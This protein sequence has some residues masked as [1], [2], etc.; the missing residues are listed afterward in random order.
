MS[1]V[2]LNVS[3]ISK[4][5]RHYN[6]E[7]L[8][9]ASWFGLKSKSIEE[10]WTLRNVNFLIHS[11]EAIGIVGQN[12]AGKSTLLKIITGTL[13]P[14]VGTVSLH[15]RVSAILELGMGFHP[16]LTG[17]ENA[18]HS[19]GM[20]GFTK[21]QIDDVIVHIE[22][23]AEIGDYFDQ[24]VRIYSSGMQMRV[25][26][27]VATA[28]RPQILIVDEALS[29]GDAYFQHKSFNRIREF[30]K[31]GT[32]LLLVSHDKSAIQAICD[33]A[34]LLDKG[35]V[36]KDGNPEEVMDFYNALIAMK[37]NSELSQTTLDSGKVQTISG[38][39]EVVIQ[40][41]VLCDDEDKAVEVVNVGNHVTLKIKTKICQNISELVLGYIIKD[42]LGQTIFGTNTH[43]LKH[44]IKDAK[45]GDEIEYNFA[46]TANLG[47]G[48]YSV[49]VAAHSTESHLSN[50]YEWKD[51][52]LIFTVINSNKNHF[53]GACWIEP[54][55]SINY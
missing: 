2:I 10:N 53:N 20:M 37:E 55:C 19:A 41:V 30:Q 38:T 47:E 34:I 8:R 4:A 51:M 39:G 15:G 16:D 25:A 14:T 17:R 45:M 9:V 42:R 22:S 24:P 28:Y 43:H 26:F 1:P 3:N 31:Q 35:T 27:A 12:G 11:G 48:S 7:W 5:Y 40:S 23:F 52:A 54:I 44:V 49:T 33:R 6:S 36:I 18:Y 13:K 21:E 46:F 29:V 50:N 32:T